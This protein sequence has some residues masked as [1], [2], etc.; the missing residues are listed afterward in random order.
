MWDDRSRR[1]RGGGS[2]PPPPAS[3]DDMSDDVADS[4]ERSSEEQ[5]SNPAA[6]ALPPARR[7]GG[8]PMAEARQHDM[9]LAPNE[10]TFVLDKTTGNVCVFM[11]PHK[12]PLSADSQPVIYRGGRFV[13]EDNPDVA[14]QQLVT[15][16][17]GQ[18]VVLHNPESAPREMMKGKN[19]SIPLDTGKTVVYRGPKSFPLWPGQEAEVIDGHR[20]DKDW[21][22][23]IRV[24]GPVAEK[25]AEALWPLVREDWRKEDGASPADGTYADRFPLGT[26]FVVRGDKTSFFIPPTGITVL[27]SSGEKTYVCRGVCLAADEYAMLLN[28]VGRVSYVYGPTTVIPCIDQ[29]FRPNPQTGRPVFKA[30]AIHENAGVLL[31]TLTEMTVAE[32]RKRIPD[33]EILGVVDDVTVLPP[34]TQLVV[35]RANRLV[36]P[37]DGVEIVKKFDAV[38]I[39]AGTACYVKHLQT[40]KTSVERGE[41]LYLPDPRI[42]EI[43]RRQLSPEQ[44]ALWFP[45]GDYNPSLVPCITVPQGTA[46]LVLGVDAGGKVTRRVLVGHTVHFLEWDETLSV[47]RVSGSDRGQPKDWKH[48]KSICYL[49]TRGNR[50]NDCAQGLR[51][52]DDCEFYVSY[53]LTV[54]F[55]QSRSDD[56]FNVDDYVFLVCDEVRSRLLGAFLA[57]PIHDIATNFVALVRDIILGKK[58]GDKH[59]LGLDFQRCG[60]KV[61]DINVKDFAIQD[62][63]L[64]SLLKGLQKV[65]VTDSIQTRQAEI[66]L[67]GDKERLRLEREKLETALAL[68]HAQA[69]YNGAKAETDDAL[70]RRQAALDNETEQERLVAEQKLAE[71]RL[72]VEKARLE[73]NYVNRQ[74]EQ[75]QGAELQLAKAEVAYKVAEVDASRAELEAKGEVS[76]LAA[77]QA[78]AK[79]RLDEMVAKITTDADAAAKV[80]A[81]I[82]PSIA[83]DLRLL[84]DTAMASKVAEALGRTASFRGMDVMELL[85]QVAGG[86][87]VV[88]RAL[89]ALKALKSAS[90]NGEGAKPATPVAPV[91]R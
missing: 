81:S 60:A 55:E 80:N 6:E 25:D 42:E 4:G 26:E 82:V 69:E 59:R 54:D 5:S 70:K 34:G 40:G 1:G 79:M 66:C 58:E 31:Q 2:R 13:P 49:W 19:G 33:V 22:L 41:K 53:T 65:G 23:K 56:W 86:S 32:A 38:H 27:P 68:A 46:A 15:A 9:V 62:A 67:Y 87:P 71:L 85:A 35:S 50:I 29:E 90:G 48:A 91:A 44:S 74:M 57:S 24:T 17:E 45:N 10:E 88:S 36:Y 20:L 14:V 72:A 39:L 18:Y 51:S 7:E 28:R 52:K 64:M 84:A 16:T 3:N 77:E 78:Q 30:V 12:E 89:E 75:A 47:I 63:Q 61:V 11:G 76:R 83:A 73:L 8:R 43:V 21:Y 37:A